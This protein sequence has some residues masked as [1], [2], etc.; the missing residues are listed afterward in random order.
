M[1]AWLHPASYQRFRMLPV[2]FLLHFELHLNSTTCLS[3]A[4]DR[5]RPF[6]TTV[7]HATKLR[8]TQTGS[9][10]VMTSSRQSNVLHSQQISVQ[11]RD[12]GQWR[13]GRLVSRMQTINLQQLCDAILPTRSKI[14]VFNLSREGNVYLQSRSMRT[15]CL[16]S[17]TKRVSS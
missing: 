14:C 7:R 6:V 15:L 17:T 10:N 16:G 12:C 9:L 5:V 2:V 8:S 1:K 13:D 3:I 11:Q 4:A